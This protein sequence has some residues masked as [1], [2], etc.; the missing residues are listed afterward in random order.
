[1]YDLYEKDV[2]RRAEGSQSD[3]GAKLS[4]PGLAHHFDHRGDPSEAMIGQKDIYSIDQSVTGHL[5]VEDVV[6]PVY[7]LLPQ[8]S[9]GHVEKAVLCVLL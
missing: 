6:G 3:H 9:R 7:R 5:L 2:Q 8:N 4:V 1:M